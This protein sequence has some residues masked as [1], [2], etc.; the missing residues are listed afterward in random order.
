MW[1]PWLHLDVHAITQTRSDANDINTSDIN[2]SLTVSASSD[3]EH[4]A[5]FITELHGRFSPHPSLWSAY[6]FGY[7][8][9]GTLSFFSIMFGYAQHASG[10]KPTAWWA[11][12]ICLVPAV[13]MWWASLVGQRFARSQMHQ[14]RTV[15]DQALNAEVSDADRVI[16]APTIS[17]V[18]SPLITPH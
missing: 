12:P 2:T 17:P 8:L 4:G 15:I 13:L 1:S 3:T 9:I 7:L 6:M 10:N 14:L 11:V 5:P 16:D 18:V